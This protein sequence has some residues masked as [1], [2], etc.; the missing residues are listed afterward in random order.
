MQEKEEALNRRSQQCLSE[1][2][3]LWL[4]VMEQGTLTECA[5]S[6]RAHRTVTVSSGNK[7][8]L[9]LTILNTSRNDPNS[10]EHLETSEAQNV[11]GTCDTQQ[12]LETANFF[13]GFLRILLCTLFSFLMLANPIY[14]K[15]LL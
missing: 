1:R 15:E 3:L 7:S 11:P 12:N 9:S 10:E 2:L 5:L 13:I 8:A 6:A 14:K 4:C